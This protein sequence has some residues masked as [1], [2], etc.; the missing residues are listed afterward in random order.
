MIFF[1]CGRDDALGETEDVDPQGVGQCGT[2]F[3]RGRRGCDGEEN[4][5]G[6]GMTRREGRTR[7]GRTDPYDPH[8][9]PPPLSPLRMVVVVVVSEGGT[10][11]LSHD[12]TFWSHW[13]S[14]VI[15]GTS[16]R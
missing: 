1:D 14:N 5:L 9:P 15:V 16:S 10:G 11:G 12:V 4:A 6:E 8:R 2:I 13:N 3:R 7:H